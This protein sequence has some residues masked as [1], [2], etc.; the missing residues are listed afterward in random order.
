MRLNN[1]AS[2][3]G[4]RNFNSGKTK[5]SLAYL[6]KR[7]PHYSRVSFIVCQLLLWSTTNG[8]PESIR[9]EANE[10]IYQDWGGVFGKRSARESITDDLI[11][12]IGDAYDVRSGGQ[13][14]VISEEF[15]TFPENAKRC[16]GFNPDS[17]YVTF[18]LERIPGEAIFSPYSNRFRED[19]AVIIFGKTPP[20]AKYFGHT[21][22]LNTVDDGKRRRN[23]RLDIQ[24]SLHDAINP[25]NINVTSDGSD[26][27]SFN[28]D[29]VIISSADQN[30]YGILSNALQQVGVSSDIFNRRAW[31]KETVNLG[32]FYPSDTI[33]ISMRIAF[34][35]DQAIGEQYLS[36]IPLTALRITPKLTKE[37]ILPYP[38]PIRA[39]KYNGDNEKKY[40]AALN[41]LEREIRKS[42]G[43]DKRAASKSIPIDLDPEECLTENTQCFFD[44]PDSAYY[45][46]V[47]G[48]FFKRGS[49]FVVIGTNHVKTGLARYANV[50]IY[51]ADKLLA[52]ASFNSVNDMDNSTKQFLPNHEHA[53]KLFAITLRKKCKKKPFCVE[54][55]FSRKNRGLPPF[56]L[57]ASRAY[58]HPNG[59]KSAYV[60]DLLPMRVIYGEKIIRNTL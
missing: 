27:D 8:L 38:I 32:I 21:E 22:Y 35:E 57:L 11:D 55:N 60:D 37:E 26:S 2:N 43:G 14:S 7:L 41:K 28:K 47:P 52:V 30:M 25:S 4:F 12:I 51:D 33:T 18:G 16:K 24:A 46:N 17:S 54:V 15:C 50:A 10:R 56:L 48:R 44:S 13:V 3:A 5:E 58:M 53:D 39:S 19:E 45:G 31:P 59:T 34:F 23:G 1:K 29:Y 20:L 42:I 9:E 36:D 6:S 40:E 49:F